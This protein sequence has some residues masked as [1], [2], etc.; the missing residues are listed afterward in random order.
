[1]NVDGASTLNSTLAV[2]GA[3][4]LNDALTVDGASDLKA[5]TID[6]QLRVKGTAASNYSADQTPAMVIELEGVDNPHRNTNFIEFQSGD[7]TL[8]RVEGM[9]MTQE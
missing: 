9:N 7:L 4:N 1:M 8:G 6:G 3:T 2:D 5:A